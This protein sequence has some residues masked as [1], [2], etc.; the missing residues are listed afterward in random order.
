MFF[1]LLQAKPCRIIQK[2]RQKQILNPKDANI[3]QQ[4]EIRH[5]RTCQD[6]SRRTNTYCKPAAMLFIFSD[7]I[8][9]SVLLNKFIFL[10]KI[11]GFTK[12]RYF[13]HKIIDFIKKIYYFL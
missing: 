1:E 11:I 9:S 8:K 10:Y 13:S 2:F 4:S 6:L 5:V 7:F 3:C 12:R